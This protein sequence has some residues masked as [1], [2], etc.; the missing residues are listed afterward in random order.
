MNLPR[1]GCYR[2]FKGGEYELLYIAR[3]SETDEPMVVYRALYPC[4]DTPNGEGIW[5]RP[6]ASWNRP[7]EIDGRMAPRFALIETAALDGQGALPEDLRATAEKTAQKKFP[8]RPAPGANGVQDAQNGHAFPEDNAPQMSGLSAPM[9]ERNGA[10]ETQNGHAFLESDKLRMTGSSSPMAEESGVQDAQ[11][12]HAFPGS[13][14]PRVEGLSAPIAEGDK[15]QETQN[16]YT[17]PGS[18]APRVEGFSAPIAERNGAQE[19]QNGHVFSKDNAPQMSEMSSP[20]AERNEVQDAQNGHAFPEDNAPQMAGFSAPMAER[21]GAQDAQNGH[22]F[23]EN[24]APQ[25]SGMSSPIA[26]RNEVQDAQ[27]GYTFPGSN[28]PQASGL[29]SFAIDGVETQE[30]PLPEPPPEE[31]FAWSAPPDEEF[32]IPPQETAAVSGK[33]PPEAPEAVL[34]RVCGYASFR[35]GQRPVIDAILSGRDVLGVMPTGSGKSVC[36][37]VPALALPGCALVVS[38]L[39]SLMKDQVAALRQAGVAAAFLNSSLTERQMD[40]A[41]A[42]IAG[43]RYKLIYIAPERLLTPRFLNL[44]R[45]LPISLVAVDEA[46]C[47]SQW[48]QDFRP[49]YLDIPEFIAALP[50]RPPL[51]AFTA[52]ATRRVRADIARLLDLRDPYTLVTG[53]DRPNLRFFVERPRERMEA[54]LRVLQEHEGQSGIVYCATRKTVEQVCQALRARGISATRYHAGLSDAERR[55]NQEAFSYDRAQV[56]VATNAFGM[57]IDKSD[58]RFVVHYNMP[59]DLESYYQEAGRAGR[60]GETADCVLF[61]GKSDVATQRFFIDKMGEEGDLDGE[62]LAKAK[63][64]AW[65]RLEQMTA[66]CQTSDCLRAHILRYFGEDAR[67]DCGSC[68][69]C[70]HPAKLEDASRLALPVLR[71]V[72]EV[73]GRVGARLI[74]STLLGSGEKRVRETG[75]DRS[76]HYGALRGMPRRVLADVIDEMIERGYLASS[77]GKYAVVRLGPR[78]KEALAGE[79][80]LLRARETEGENPAPKAKGASHGAA[81]AGLYGALRGLRL[82]IAEKRGVPAYMIFT[83]ATLRAMCAMLPETPEQLLEVPGVGETKLRAYGGEFLRAIARWKRK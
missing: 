53:F 61:F 36:Y 10:Q 7:V 63:R 2:H 57:G 34:K 25:M 11:N 43:G 65:E 48:G 50:Q 3:H 41:L 17:F 5:A 4:P 59:K 76:P 13:N 52:T 12:G 26:E 22:A 81:N 39:I 15:A 75:L 49:S 33:A 55:E 60:D 32:P 66:Y 20:I 46:H 35:A 62:M 77:G 28:V 74:R 73:N 78:A 79:A 70:L 51:C 6:L 30:A 69:N 82:R 45:I 56:M 21:S 68:G 80:V 83:D 19:T 72:Q 8:L 64:A 54:L 27:N 71:C 24:N 42:N 29:T 38:P 16:G 9:A 31:D 44:S 58:V 14:A 18:N 37:Q 1:K 40:A 67:K 23:P 47:I